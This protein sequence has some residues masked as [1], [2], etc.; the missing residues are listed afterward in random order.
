MSLVLSLRIEEVLYVDGNKI[1]VKDVRST[2]EVDLELESGEVITVTDK[3]STEV[4]PK[5]LVSVGDASSNANVARLVFKA[6]RSIP[7]VRQEMVKA[8][9]E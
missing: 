1:V 5:T 8:K 3:K 7:I 9:D 6:P 4:Y 2:S